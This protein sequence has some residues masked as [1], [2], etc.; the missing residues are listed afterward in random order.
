MTMTLKP[1]LAVPMSKGNITNWNDWAVEEKYDGHRL[2]VE[3]G[4]LRVQAWTRPRKR[5][6]SSDKTMAERTLPPHLVAQFLKLPDGIYDGELMA[7]IED[8]T[9]TDVTRTDLQD[10]LRFVV[11]DILEHNGLSTRERP[12]Q[13]RHLLLHRIFERLGAGI[14]RLRNIALSTPVMVTCEADVTNFVARI[15]EQGG[16]GAILKRKAATYQA[17]KRSP[18]FIKVKRLQH[19]VL[20]VIGFEPTR[21]KVLDRG[22][23]ATV[24]LRDDNGVETSCKTLN[25]EELQAFED[26]WKPI[27]A[28]I[29]GTADHVQRCINTMHPA[30]GR[31]LMINFPMRTR[32]G[33]YQGPIMWD[34]WEDE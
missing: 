23:F 15:W 1:M 3:V 10:T 29:E 27:A 19:A 9:A 28:N 8:A 31:R 13:E 11:F 22:R 2:I 5:A 17:G 32:D 7:G 25:D 30:I 6:G 14:R 18:D 20:T 12:W 21:G 4:R 34:R 33:N 26:A 16:E 24:L